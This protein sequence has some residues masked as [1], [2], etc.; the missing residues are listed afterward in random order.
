[1]D[2]ESVKTLDVEDSIS[3]LAESGKDVEKDVESNAEHK[4]EG[5]CTCSNCSTRGAIC[6]ISGLVI[7]VIGKYIVKYFN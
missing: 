7:G 2:V 4:V 6:G 5:C 3:Q 1:M